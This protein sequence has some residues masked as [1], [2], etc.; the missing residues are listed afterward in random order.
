L[1]PL[2]I[3]Q[4]AHFRSIK[5][6]QMTLFDLGD[7]VTELRKQG[8]NLLTWNRA[9]NTQ[10]G[11]QSDWAIFTAFCEGTGRAALP[12]LPDT[13]FLFLSKQ[14]NLGLKVATVERRLTS[15]KYIHRKNGH[16]SPVDQRCKDA[17]IGARRQR[18]EKSNGK[19]ALTPEYLRKIC[20]TLR[21]RTNADI[22]DRALMVFGFASGLR[23]S[24]IAALDVGDVEFSKKGLVVDLGHSKQDQVGKGRTLGIFP[25]KRA[26]TDPVRTMREW[27]RRRGRTSGP[28]FTRI[29]TGD[30]VTQIR[31]SGE[32]I[33][34]I[35]QR[36][37][38]M[39][40]LDP[41]QY[42]AHSLRAGV[43][44]E[45]AI[46]GASDR[47]IMAITG[48]KSVAVMQ[49]YIRRPGAF[50]KDDPIAAAL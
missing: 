48:H 28:L 19:K 21:Q 26:L 36:S 20:A 44:T 3:H 45:A 30:T 2:I 4:I 31:M 17:L 40:G 43:A 10:I 46:R 49:R 50:L 25:G 33:A 12:A 7:D 9:K 13:V 27:I 47:Q 6:K 29:Q 11:Y 32:A 35:V 34:D 5:L 41:R 8:E 38:E 39:I 23:R 24:E 16:L 37:V 42:G 14:L 15:I 1:H 22:R 18:H